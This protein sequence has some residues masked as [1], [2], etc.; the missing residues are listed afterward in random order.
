MASHRILVV[1]HP[2]PLSRELLA[3][4]NIVH[5]SP[6]SRGLWTALASGVWDACVFEEERLCA[7]VYDL[8]QHARETQPHLAL[9][10]AAEEEA[11]AFDATLVSGADDWLKPKSANRPAARVLTQAVAF[12]RT[13]ARRRIAAPQ[14]HVVVLDWDQL[15]AAAVRATLARQD[16]AV[17][18]VTDVR[19]A[20]RELR[21]S[22]AD[23]LITP[24]SVSVNGTGIV[25]AA[26]RY[27]PRLRIVV[28]SDVADLE[29]TATAMGQGAHDYLLRPVG[30]EQALGAVTSAWSAH[31][32]TSPSGELRAQL[33][34]VL[35]LEP[36]RLQAQLVDQMLAQEGRFA[37]TT[38]RDLAQARRR[39][40]ERN[41]DAILY[42]PAGGRSEA[43]RFLHELS[44]VN[45]QPAIILLAPGANPSFHEQALRMGAQDIISRQRLGS[46]AL[47]A[48]V[49][50]AVRRNQYHL[51][52]E[53]FVRDLQLRE[54]SQQEVVRRSGDAILIVDGQG[55]VVFCNPAAERMFSRSE[56]PLL[57]QHFPYEPSHKGPREIQVREGDSP[58]VAEMTEVAIDWNGAPGRLI[59]LRDTTERRQAQELRDRLAHSE[60][61]AAIGQLAAGVTHEINNPATYVVA[62]L[63][64]MLDVLTALE[65]DP[66][67]RD[68]ARAK[69][70]EL[71]DM[72]RE[73]LDGMSRIRSITNDLRTFSRIDSQ[74]VT[75]VD[76]NEC[77]IS[78][79]K[80]AFNEI[81][82]RAH[83][84]QALSD[85]PHIPASR[86]KLAQVVTNLLVNAAQAIPEGNVEQNRVTVR[87]GHE[88]DEIWLQVEDTGRGIPAQIRAKI[89]DPFFTT[90]TRS[91]GTGLGLALC[92]D[93]VRQH[94]GT[95]VMNPQ[96][97]G[98]GTCFEMRLPI[99]T[100]LEL[101]QPT[102]ATSQVVPRLR[103]SRRL[104]VLLIDDEPLVLRSLR[105]MLSEHHVD[106][107]QSGSEALSLLQRKQD[108]D[109]IF[110]DLMMPEMDGT[111]VHAELERR[112]PALLE[113]LVFCSGGAFTARTK[114]FLEQTKRPLVEKPLTR[115]SFERVVSEQLGERRL[116]VVGEG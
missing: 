49:R 17:T 84:I 92:A 57:G 50:N 18:R 79:C 91:Q 48:R 89:F 102:P 47:G 24:P 34:Q 65:L 108:Y 104:R 1:G 114:Q 46:E 14:C 74:E 36:E 7:E 13:R 67:A 95:L 80:I 103:K 82:Q 28:A 52:H 69:L 27:D 94:Q 45:P 93:I 6:M 29:G 23:V 19:G 32:N 112:M 44:C 111:V 71:S 4:G 21:M 25:A 61:L 9:L 75:L 86:G 58:C 99:D 41:F 63:T 87:T 15:E 115:E 78:A 109:L 90:K 110:C 30:S 59:S 54:A 5:H 33:L 66:T 53:R 22:T 42:R 37:T 107:A 73:N 2:S 83:L 3:F 72:V 113:R 101:S 77:V 38:V 105:R 76:L 51:A 64:T 60:R 100:Q 97:E 62:N 96:L 70:R 10:V 26:L 56:R 11:T 88:G 31:T 81:R 85:L 106:T 98:G 116:K 20:L 12:R 68:D 39:L 8:V 35:V 16:F 40:S 43:I 55:A